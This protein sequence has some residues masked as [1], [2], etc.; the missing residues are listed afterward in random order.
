MGFHPHSADIDQSLALQPLIGHPG[1]C[2]RRPRQVPVALAAERRQDRVAFTRSQSQQ[3][4]YLGSRSAPLFPVAHTN[5]AAQPLVEFRN[6]AVVVRDAKIAHPPAHVLGELMQPV[7]HR[8]PPRA[9]GQSPDVVLEVLEGPIRPAQ[10]LSPEGETEELALV[11]LDHPAL[12]LVD[13]QRQL[14]GEKARHAVLHPGTGS[15]RFDEDQQVV[16]VSGEP[17]STPLQFVVE[18]IQQNIGEQRRKGTALRHTQLRYLNGLSDQ[19]TRPQVT[20]HQCQQSLVV[21]LSGHTGHQD[22]VLDVV[23]KFR[24]IQI[25]GDAVT[26]LDMALYLPECSMGGAPRSKAEARLR[27]PRVEDWRE[28]LCDG[29]L[30]DPV[31]TVGIPSSRSPPP[32]LGMLTRRTG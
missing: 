9:P 25:D 28:H 20:A 17:V 15:D 23:E 24:Q 3:V 11:G 31:V 32:G 8:D 4:T 12:L 18:V 6:R 10:L 5:A 30:D 7:A 1:L 26:G 14:P 27:E 2:R 22:V 19:N 16:R 21:H 13:H 29:L